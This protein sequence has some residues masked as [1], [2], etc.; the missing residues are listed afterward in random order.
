M[1]RVMQTT[2]AK[3]DAARRWLLQCRL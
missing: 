3:L 2:H 1:I